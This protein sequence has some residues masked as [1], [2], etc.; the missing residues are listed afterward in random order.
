MKPLIPLTLIATLIIA[1]SCGPHYYK[2]ERIPD[3]DRITLTITLSD[4]IVHHDSL[5]QCAKEVCR[6][7]NVDGSPVCSSLPLDLQVAIHNSGP[8]VYLPL[9]TFD[10]GYDNFGSGVNVETFVLYEGRGWA[11]D[12]TPTSGVVVS[13]FHP[14]RNYDDLLMYLGPDTTVALNLIMWNLTAAIVGFRDEIPLGHYEFFIKLTARC[15]ADTD[16]PIWVGK[17]RS[18]RVSLYVVD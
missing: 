13:N 18:N 9:K 3:S 5:I 12:D 17:T 15:T 2:V 16:K 8:G 4:S 10:F 6:L 7:W 1:A 14:C 11:P